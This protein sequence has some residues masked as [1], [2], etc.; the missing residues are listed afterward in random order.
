[1]GLAQ[2]GLKP[3]LLNARAVAFLRAFLPVP[4]ASPLP[5][6]IIIPVSISTT[7][8]VT[9]VLPLAC[10]TAPKISRFAPSSDLGLTQLLLIASLIRSV[11]GSRQSSR[12]IR[13][14][15]RVRPSFLLETFV[16]SLEA[17]LLN[18]LSA[19]ITAS[20]KCDASAVLF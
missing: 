2:D 19:E 15:N 6:C 5:V 4:L 3:I 17:L 14:V 16:N 1:M 13:S 18:C 7:F 8:V 9:R 10:C 20:L 12:D 11:L